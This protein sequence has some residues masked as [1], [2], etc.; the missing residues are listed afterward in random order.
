M[1]IKKHRT[2]LILLTVFLALILCFLALLSHENSAES[3][4]GDSAGSSVT[5]TELEDLTSVSYTDYASG[6]TMSFVQEDGTWYAAD[7]R[8]IPLNQSYPESIAGTFSSLTAT[9][10]IQDPDALSDYGL[11][12]P[13]YTVKVE[14]AD[15]TLTEFTVGNTAGDDYYLMLGGQDNPIYTVS[16]TVVSSLQY[17][18]DTMVEKDTLPAIGSGNLTK[19]EITE[20]QDTVSYSS[21]DDDQSETIATIAG[22]YGAMTLTTCASYHASSEELT[23]FGLDAS[24]RTEVRLT[25]TESSGD[26]ESEPLTYSI[27]IGDETSDSE[28]YVQVQDSDIV[29]LVSSDILNNLLGAS[30]EES[31]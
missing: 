13:S 24:S 17:D 10:E 1:D 7:D 23:S 31:S 22:G 16:S 14:D 5:V 2:L 11:D 27:Y 3:S 12:S 21:E 28:R 29:Y 20:G 30:Q 6:T 26:D 4:G 8:E 19:A 15:G 18:L 9:R 25:Y